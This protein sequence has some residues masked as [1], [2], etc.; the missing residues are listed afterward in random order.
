MTDD[1]IRL[2]AAAIALLPLLGVALALGKIFSDW[3]S[4]VAR[5]PGAAE[6]VQPVGLLG[7]ALTEAIALFALIVAFIILFV[8]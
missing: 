2:L 8:G 1:G 7:F 6:V 4:S 3:I 5:N